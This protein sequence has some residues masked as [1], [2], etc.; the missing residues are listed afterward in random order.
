MDT[1][2]IKSPEEVLAY[3]ADLKRMH[4]ERMMLSN[5]LTDE[6]FAHHAS[7]LAYAI[8]PFSQHDQWRCM[9]AFRETAAIF[10]HRAPQVWQ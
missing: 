3:I 1:T 8:I 9:K 10:P 5:G 6:A 4:I 2:G 7:I